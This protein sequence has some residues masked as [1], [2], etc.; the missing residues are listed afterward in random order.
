MKHMSL[1]DT[2]RGSK[3]ARDS[4]ARIRYEAVTGG[5]RTTPRVSA[6][7]LGTL[8]GVHNSSKRFLLAMVQSPRLSKRGQSGPDER[9]FRRSLGI[10][11]S[12]LVCRNKE[13][14]AWL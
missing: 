7:T 8:P 14:V 11:S 1:E 9:W 6:H 4:R 5:T 3:N 13:S 12:W 10:T 2:Y